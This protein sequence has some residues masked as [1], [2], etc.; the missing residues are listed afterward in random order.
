MKGFQVQ[1]SSGLGLQAA[2]VGMAREADY[3]GGAKLRGC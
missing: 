2:G 1:L 3:R